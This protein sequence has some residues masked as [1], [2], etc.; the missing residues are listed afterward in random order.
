M[1][2]VMSKRITVNVPD[3]VA[4]RLEH[5]EN[6]SAYVSEA[7]RRRMQSES[8]RAILEAV[9]FHFTEEGLQRMRERLA[10]GQAKLTPEFL[11]RSR[12][13]FERMRTEE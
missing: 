7:V 9:G 2:N 11:A 12:E 8:T 13:A 10:E 4:S 1:V 3:D 5:E 6:V